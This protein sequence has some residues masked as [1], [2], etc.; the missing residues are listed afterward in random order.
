MNQQSFFPPPPREHGGILSVN[1]R[2]SRR[3]LTT[4]E[5]IHVTLRSEIAV[6]ERSLLRHKDIIKAVMKKA[7]ARFRIKVYRYSICSNH[8]HLVIR[9]K[10]RTEIQNF[11]RVFAGHTA[12]AILKRCPPT[13]EE[14]E[15]IAAAQ[16][17]CA[18]NLRKF[19][20][21]LIY[22]RLITWGREFTRVMDYL[23]RNTLEALHII[24]YTPRKK[25][26]AGP[27]QT[28][29]PSST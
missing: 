23:M 6:G 19:W 17:G 5:P 10:N 28:P 27:R 8:I 21:Y 9:G 25:A 24:A 29:R 22:S 12:Q 26:R 14:I 1:K 20:Q 18:K 2:R 13:Q 16:K 3:S 7:E 11:F 15:K 4:K